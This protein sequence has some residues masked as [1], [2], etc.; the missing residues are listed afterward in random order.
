[1][2]H[3]IG[4]CHSF[5]FSV[6]Q[7]NKYYQNET[8]SEGSICRHLLGSLFLPGIFFVSDAPVVNCRITVIELL[9]LE[10]TPRMIKFQPPAT[11]R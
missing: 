4:L 3:K 2:S 7:K 9:G 11:G 5:G 8:I 1:M 6:L 10:G